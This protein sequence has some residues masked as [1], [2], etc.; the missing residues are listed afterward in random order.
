M[1]YSNGTLILYGGMTDHGLDDDKFYQFSISIKKLTTEQ[2]YWKTLNITGVNPGSRAHHTMNFF[3]PDFLVIFG[4]KLRKDNELDYVVANDLFYIDMKEL[5]SSTPFVANICPS[6]R[7]GH[8]SA[9]NSNFYPPEHLIIGGLDKTF[10]AL[11]AYIVREID[12]TSDKK[13]VYEQKKLHASTNV[14][15]ED[16]DEIFETAKKAILHNKKQ[17][18]ILEIANLQVNRD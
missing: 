2:N 15:Y 10:G 7:F 5:N 3:K 11:D 14:N 4:G 12:L 9:F 18:E 1:V 8:A 17:I 6:A 13:W 16:K